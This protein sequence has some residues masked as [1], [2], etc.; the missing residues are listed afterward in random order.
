VAVFIPKG[1]RAGPRVDCVLHF[2]GWRGRVPEVL[3]RYQLIEQFAA[4]GRNAVLVVPQG[5]RGA[6]D[7][8][9]GKLEDPGGFRRFMDE[10]LRVLRTDPRLAEAA[11][12][13]GRLVLSAHSGGGRV[14]AEILAV[15]GLAEKVDE[16]WLFDALY[17]RAEK[18]RAWQQRSGGRWLTVY[19]DR[20]GTTNETAK[21]MAELRRDGVAL[22]AVEESGAGPEALRRRQPI[23]VHTDLGHDDVL[24]GR[25]AFRVFLETSGL[26]PLAGR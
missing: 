13:A 23:F 8:F 25:Q 9:G 2:H 5:P 1:F 3:S 17:S 22:A 15:G 21:I 12:E 11:P 4:S 14:V 7:S 6:A 19:T 26:E 10:L 24:H 16:V 20:G 18:Y